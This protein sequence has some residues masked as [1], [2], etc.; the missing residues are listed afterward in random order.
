MIRYKI[1]HVTTYQY[2][3]S[4]SLCQNVA[5]LSIRACDRQQAEP[6]VLAITPEP[7]VIEERIDYFGNPVHYFTVQEPHR[8]LTVEASH[9]VAVASRA[10]ADPAQTPPWEAV[11][12]QL[13]HDRSPDWLDA[14][15]FVFDSRFAGADARYAG[16]A[17]E[18]FTPGRPILEAAL[19]LAHRIHEEFV[20]D[21]KATTVATPVSEVFENRRGVCQ[22]FAHLLLA[23]FRSLGL[24][25]RYVSGYLATVAPPGQARLIGADAGHAWVSVFCGEAGWVD[26]DPTNDLIPDDRHVLVAWGRDYEDVSPLKGVILG[27]GKHTVRVAVDVIPQEEI[28][29]NNSEMTTPS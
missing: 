24:A 27:G 9:Q 4:V 11:R 1:T 10:P 20:Y 26:L 25:A 21:P 18:S 15:Q 2:T 29:N 3:E 12:D 22:D 7:A 14:Y 16:F 5:H 28:S 8:E 23:C 6:S 19:H 13:T 17:G